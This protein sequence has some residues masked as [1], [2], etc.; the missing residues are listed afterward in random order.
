MWSVSRV[1]RIVGTAFVVILDGF[2]LA[3]GYGQWTVGLVAIVLLVGGIS[4]WALIHRP[5]VGVDGET[6]VIVNPWFSYKVALNSIFFVGSGPRGL[7]VRRR[8]RSYEVWAV[9]QGNITRWTGRE[10][11]S[12][13]VVSVIREAVLQHGGV[14]DS[15]SR[16]IR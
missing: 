8:G 11:R 15:D 1:G 2:V 12:R 6:L 5:W 10:S 9:Q 13:R 3:V 14:L 16:D 7:V 4:A